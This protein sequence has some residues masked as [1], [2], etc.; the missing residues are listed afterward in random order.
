MSSYFAPFLR[1]TAFSSVLCAIALLPGTALGAAPADGARIDTSD[2]NGNPHV[3]VA[4]PE[5]TLDLS[6][7]VEAI[8]S[9]SPQWEITYTNSAY[10]PSPGTLGAGCTLASSSGNDVITCEVASAAELHEGI[11]IWTGDGSDLVQIAAGNAAA[12]GAVFLR[13][14]SGLVTQSA[15]GGDA[16]DYFNTLEGDDNYNGA[17]Y[18]RGGRGLDEYVPSTNAYDVVDY[19]DFDRGTTN[20]VSV[21]FD[22]VANDGNATYDGGFENAGC[23]QSSSSMNGMQGTDG[24]DTLTADSGSSVLYGKKGNDTMDGGDATDQLIGGEGNDTITGGGGHDQVDGDDASGVGAGNDTIFLRDSHFDELFSCGGGTDSAQLDAA[25]TDIVTAVD[26]ETLDRGSSAGGSAA[27]TDPSKSFIVPNYRPQRSGKKIRFKSLTEARRNIRDAGVN[28]Q[29]QVKYVALK[30]VSAQLRERV[31]DGD[32]VAQ[33]VAP[34]AILTV[35]IAPP[36]PELRVT[37]YREALD[38][39][40]SRCPYGNKKK[41]QSILNAIDDA[42]L[43][44]AQSYLKKHQCK[45]RRL[46]DVIDKKAT[47][48]TIRNAIVINNKTKRGRELAIALLVQR[49]PRQDFRINVI[50]RPPADF[51]SRPEFKQEI[52]LG[53]DGKLTAGLASAVVHLVPYEV[54]TGR[55]LRGLEVKVVR[56]DET[57][58]ASTRTGSTGGLTFT[59]PVDFVGELDIRVN[60]DLSDAG[61]YETLEAWHTIDVVDRKKKPFYTK[62]GRYFKWSKSKNR[63]LQTKSPVTVSA[64]QQQVAERMRVLSQGLAGNNP[65]FATAAS[66]LSNVSIPPQQRLQDVANNVGLL[67]GALLAGSKP[68]GKITGA[69]IVDVAAVQIGPGGGLLPTTMP[70][71]LLPS[72]GDIDTATLV[73]NDGASLVGLDGATLVGNDGASLVGLDGATLAN[74][75]GTPL[76]GQDGSTFAA[77][78]KLISDKGVG[79]GGSG[80]LP[81]QR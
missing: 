57:V 38:Y 23:T 15:I 59:V 80:F 50:E 45:V 44:F 3:I 66:I 48:A 65:L 21:T 33:S 77:G 55:K 17:N 8:E 6:L 1:A 19:Y 69:T 62:S 26:C 16:N 32:I 7:Y 22:C 39:R 56:P 11:E 81:V 31:E 47:D 43:T 64:V 58:L 70:V 28:V 78:M 24:N 25:T 60:V 79:L 68:D 4:W 36:Y 76:V 2:H 35:G 13:D 63:Y 34:G 74:V 52:G 53:D 9:P 14:S 40:G 51:K 49:P 61:G 37:V 73:G 67:P 54:P 75:A 71:A 46:K 72:V 29:L 18:I 41:M 27:E 12:P 5:N 10:E 20:P 42:P 30:G